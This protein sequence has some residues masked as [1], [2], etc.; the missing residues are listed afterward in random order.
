MFDLYGALEAVRDLK[1]SGCAII[2]HANPCGLSEGRDQRKVFEKAWAGDSVSA[3]GSVI[4]FNQTVVLE[5]ARFLN[6]DADDKSQRKFVEILAA[7]AFEENALEYLKQHK[8]LRIVVFDPARLQPTHDMKFI[9]NALL[10]QDA[11]RGLLE[12]VEYVTRKK[13]P[14]DGDLMRF[15]LTAVRQ[16]KSNA[17]CVA[18]RCID[19]DLHL[20]GMGCGQ[21]NRVNSTQ[22]T[23]ERCRQNLIQTFTG[24]PEELEAYIREEMGKAVLFSDAFFPFPDNVDLSHD[25][26]IQTIVQ[27]GGSI[28]DKAVIKKADELEITLIFTGMRHF[29]H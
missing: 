9:Y 5:T 27:P 6:L 13:D 20:L 24:N 19:G 28:R 29:K 12:K 22:L 1:G 26:G 7:P 21:P 10:Y 3:F 23:L 18:R 14:V 11:D 4:A 8:N 15:G 25:A 16:L 2:K 17:I